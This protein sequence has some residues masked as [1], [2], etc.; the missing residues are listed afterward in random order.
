MVQVNGLEPPRITTYRL[1]ED[2]F[3]SQPQSVACLPRS[4]ELISPH[5]YIFFLLF[6]R[7]DTN[8]KTFFESDKCFLKNFWLFKHPKKTKPWFNI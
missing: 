6:Q 8:I 4:E 7:T 1:K 2:L 5:P 3:H